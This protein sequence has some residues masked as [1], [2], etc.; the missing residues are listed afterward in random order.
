MFWWF[1]LAGAVFKNMPTGEA[2]VDVQL[3][4]LDFIV[5][6]DVQ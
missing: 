2:D 5:E 4:T 3:D 1:I 6:V